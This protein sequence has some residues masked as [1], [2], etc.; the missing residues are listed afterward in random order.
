[1]IAVKELQSYTAES[2][3]AGREQ[4]LQRCKRLSGLV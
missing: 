2:S 3:K 4:Q 1:M